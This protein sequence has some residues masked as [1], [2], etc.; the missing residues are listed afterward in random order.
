MQLYPGIAPAS[1]HIYEVSSTLRFIS[2]FKRLS[3]TFLEEGRERVRSRIA[4]IEA[5]AQTRILSMCI[6]HHVIIV[7]CL[8]S[9]SP[10]QHPIK[11]RCNSCI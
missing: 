11:A 5:F 3:L 4:F 1:L 9:F 10:C 7:K 2:L 8:Q 6:L